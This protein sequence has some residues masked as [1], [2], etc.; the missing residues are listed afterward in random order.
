MANQPQASIGDALIFMTKAAAAC[1]FAAFALVLLWLW[2]MASSQEELS[3]AR[4]LSKVNEAQILRLKEQVEQVDGC[5]K[6]LINLTSTEAAAPA[7][8][9]TARLQELLGDACREELQRRLKIAH[10]NG[11]VTNARAYAVAI[12]RLS[13][14]SARVDGQAP[15]W[16]PPTDAPIVGESGPWERY[17]TP[18][19]EAP[20]P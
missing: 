5:V 7:N 4:A 3:R 2:G 14:P 18:S 6:L 17:Q 10:E 11:D 20:Q 13:V 1:L 9:Y 8:P 16:T 19:A 12:R 15:A